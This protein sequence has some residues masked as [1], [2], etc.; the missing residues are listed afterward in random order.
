M[1]TLRTLAVMGVSFLSILATE[2]ALA[3]PL[4]PV[5]D[6]FWI[7]KTTAAGATTEFRDSFNDGTLPPSGPDD[8]LSNPTTYVLSGA[9][10][11][12]SESGG[13]L[14]MTP[15]LGALTGIS[16]TSSDYSTVAVR[17]LSTNP[18]NSSFLGQNSSFEIHGLFDLLALPTINGQSFGIRA[19]DRA[20]ALGNLG[21]DTYVLLVGFGAEGN[22]NAGKVTLALRHNDF[23]LDSST[24][25]ESFLI[26]PLLTGA[27]QIELIFS[28]AMDANVLTASYKLYDTSNQLLNSGSIGLNNTL[29][30]YDGENYIRGGF[31]STDVI[32]VPEPATLA[33]LGLGFAGLMFARKRKTTV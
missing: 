18:A 16:G 1:I 30:I 28:K 17:Q 8:S 10:G 26:E 21:N 33:L 15:S 29:N 3:I 31:Q 22:P 24:L 23:F 27:S 32:T 25:L 12:T 14:T 7:V 2:A 19:T 5:I 9:G 11:F 4:T 20:V 6:E 13:K